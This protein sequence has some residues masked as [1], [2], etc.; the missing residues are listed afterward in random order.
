[1]LNI[2]KNK[3]SGER[4]SWI[5]FRLN[6]QRPN[7]QRIKSTNIYIYFHKIHISILTLQL[8]MLKFIVFFPSIIFSKLIF[9]SFK[10]KYDYS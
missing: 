9:I 8:N 7:L 1:M 6:R 10:K 2:F 5:K 3:N 4:N